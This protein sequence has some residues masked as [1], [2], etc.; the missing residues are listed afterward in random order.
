MVV[1]GDFVDAE[2]GG[3][4]DP[5]DGQNLTEKRAKRVTPRRPSLVAAKLSAIAGSRAV[6]RRISKGTALRVSQIQT[7]FDAPT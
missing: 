7:R 4:D 2:D 3:L 5:G 6:M 1:G